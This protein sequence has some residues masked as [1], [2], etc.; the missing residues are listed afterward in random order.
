[1]NV[2]RFK[3]AKLSGIML[4]SAFFIA[5]ISVTPVSAKVDESDL[6]PPGENESQILHLSDG[7]QMVGKIVSVQ[8]GKVEFETSRGTTT[9]EVTDI[10]KIETIHTSK[11]KG[12]TYWFPNPNQTRLY[13]GPTG[14]ML[15]KGTGYFTD[16]ELFFPGVAYGITD[17]ISIG[18]GISIFPG[19]SMGDQIWY[20]Q[21]KVGF[22]VGDMFDFAVSALII[23]V[24]NTDADDDID[25]F[26]EPNTVGVIF[27]VGTYGNEDRSVTF[28]LGF[29]YA[30]D[31]IANKPAIIFGGDYRVARRV[32]LVTENWIFPEV[33]EPLV[34][35]GI[36]FFGE[37]LS[38]DLG[39]F[40]VLNEDA[41][42][43]GFPVV[44]FSYNFGG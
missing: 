7:S 5:A 17:N 40:N 44:N 25:A 42:F 15:A 30:D 3:I 23:Q 14:R 2:R 24:P 36:R 11:M 31:D 20:L 34:S 35:Y 8:D 18:A 9:I 4:G 43:P 28:G 10:E 38:V 27:G 13:F 22:P 21:P 26:D 39:F 6:Q 19:V 37:S 1:M 41:L 33:D 12:S 32:S 16:V 29:G